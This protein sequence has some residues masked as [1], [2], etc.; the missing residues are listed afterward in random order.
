[1][2]LII[3]SSCLVFL[4]AVSECSSGDI[5]RV[6]QDSGF[7][8]L[9][10]SIRSKMAS[11]FDVALLK[12]SLGEFSEAALVFAVSKPHQLRGFHFGGAQLTVKRCSTLHQLATFRGA[13]LNVKFGEFSEAVLVFAVSTLQHTFGGAQLKVKCEYVSE[14][15]LV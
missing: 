9:K 8:R 11:F 14:A 5:E 10:S 2:V 12:V 1:M 15:A 4:A 13:Q 6:E 7:L 3:A